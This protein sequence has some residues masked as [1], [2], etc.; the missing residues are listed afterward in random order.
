MPGSEQAESLALSNDAE[1]NRLPDTLLMTNSKSPKPVDLPADSPNDG[2]GT[3]QK[4]SLKARA[5]GLLWKLGVLCTKPVLSRLRGYFVE[6]LYLLGRSNEQRL[7][8]V[9]T[10]I[11]DAR[12][13]IHDARHSIHDVGDSIHDVGDSIRSLAESIG[14]LRNSISDLRES[15]NRSS[16][17]INDLRESISCSSVLINDIKESVHGHDEHGRLRVDLQTQLL[18]LATD[19]DALRSGVNSSHRLVEVLANRNMFFFGNKLLSR[20]PYG[21]ILA[22]ADDIPFACIL[23]EGEMWE[24]GTSKL[25]DLLLKKGMTFVDVGAHV[26]IHTI[27]AGRLVGPNGTVIAVEPTPSLF[28]LL[29]E[30]IHLNGLENVCTCLNIAASSAEGTATLHLSDIYGHNSLNPLTNEKGQVGVRTC[31]LDELLRDAQ[32]VAMIKIDVEGAELQVL[33]GMRQTVAN[34]HEI[35]LIVE[36]N[37]PHLDRAKI[38]STEWFDRFF[39]YG[40]DLFVLDE[41]ERT[42]R[43]IAKHDASQ[44]PS[45]N[46]VFVRPNTA[47]WRQLKQHEI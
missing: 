1:D 36:Y 25:L 5:S 3:T 22:P 9:E 24:P 45:A 2:A 20:T 23:A 35:V 4:D 15:V 18:M 32:S 19:L 12:H 6:P 29:Q 21:Y 11:H 37:L 43:A 7:S 13:S 28:P 14:S 33:E 39:D 34:H 31:S 38:T 27:H 16:E 41:I 30:S 44:L 42:W 8:N 26:G 47:A 40:F 17:L 46:L 10:L